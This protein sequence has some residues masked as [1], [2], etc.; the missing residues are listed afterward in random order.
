MPDNGRYV[1][2][3]TLTDN[4]TD[5][6]KLISKDAWDV[7]K[8]TAEQQKLKRLK[9]TQFTGYGDF[10]FVAYKNDLFNIL[11]GADLMR[12]L[13][14]ASYIQYS[15]TGF[16][17]IIKRKPMKR[18]DCMELLGL[19]RTA[20]N[21]F[22]SLVTHL[23]IVKEDVNGCVILSDK[24]FYRGKVTKKQLDKYSNLMRINAD[25]IRQLYS[26]YDDKG[27]KKLSY[28][29]RLIPYVDVETNTICIQPDLMAQNH[30]P[31]SAEISEMVGCD[32]RSW[33][34]L[35]KWYLEVGIKCNDRE[36]KLIKVIHDG[37]ENIIVINPNVF[38]G[39]DSYT[40]ILDL[41]EEEVIN[42]G[43]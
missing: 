29:Y 2:Y 15:D 24:Y 9:A 33:K 5:E 23:R 38:Y 10:Y 22:W 21:S 19:K 32:E 37:R 41:M 16:K 17:I 31:T 35:K 3:D 8:K 42:V 27:L 20:F 11:N 40:E 6:F 36:S 26:D 28:L 13:Y 34:R 25:V 30:C 4:L 14:M 1:V 18:N 7:R 43:R 12:V 39:G